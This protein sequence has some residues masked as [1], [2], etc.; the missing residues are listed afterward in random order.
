MDTERE[1]KGGTDGE[2]SIDIHTP[3]RVKETVGS[4]LFMPW[5]IQGSQNKCTGGQAV[6]VNVNHV[7]LK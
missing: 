1:G 3:P 6:N 7:V 4:C 2:T 5:C